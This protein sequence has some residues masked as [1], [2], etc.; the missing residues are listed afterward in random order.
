MKKLLFLAVTAL[1]VFSCSKKST[2]TPNSVPGNVIEY[3][4]SANEPGTYTMGYYDGF[5]TGTA[6]T[7]VTS[8]WNQKVTIPAGTKAA[9]I[10]FTAGQSPPFYSNNIGV[11]SIK[12]NGEIV[13]TG[14]KQFTTANTLAEASYD[15]SSN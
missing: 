6:A 4:F 13:A 7:I 1:T 5:S 15:Y 3:S 9:K 14:S 11:I 12:I 2:P 8:T 10:F